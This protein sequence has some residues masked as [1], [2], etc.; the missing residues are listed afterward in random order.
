M[1]VERM[2]TCC[3]IL[4]AQD[5]GYEIRPYDIDSI[6][7]IPMPELILL[8]RRLMRRIYMDQIQ[9]P[10]DTFQTISEA[11]EHG[12]GLSIECEQELDTFSRIQIEKE[13]ILFEQEM[14]ESMKNRFQSL[15]AAFMAEM[16]IEPATA[17]MASTL[18]RQIFD[19]S[20]T[21]KL[22]RRAADL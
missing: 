5:I 19:Q 17:N 2:N 12:Y 15:S 8:K 6:R 3:F 20:P 10:H 14:Y 1:D 18:I 9:N 11:H 16:G 7:T 13:R 21:E 22:L 4:H